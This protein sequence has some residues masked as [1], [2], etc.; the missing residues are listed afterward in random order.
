MRP[1][2][3]A[4][5]RRALAFGRSKINLHSAEDPFVPHAKWPTPGSADRRFIVAATM[6]ALELVRK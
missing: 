6:D 4:A 2:T 5:G 1:V 3:F